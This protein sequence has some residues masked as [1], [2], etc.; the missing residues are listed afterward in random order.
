M[1][2]IAILPLILILN[3]CYFLAAQTNSQE[4]Y[5]AYISGNMV[6]WKSVIDR[7]ASNSSGKPADLA[8]LINYQYGYVGWAIGYKKTDEAKIY[9]EKAEKNLDLLDRFPEYASLV[10]SYKAA[11]YGY[12]IGMN[13]VLAPVLGKKS[14][15]CARAAIKIDE[16]NFLGWVQY[17]NTEF[18]MPSTFGGSKKDALKYYLKAQALLEAD[19]NLVRENWNYLSLL[20]V[21][22]QTYSYLGDHQSSKKYLDRILELEPGFTWAKTE[23]YQQI[24]KNMKN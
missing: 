22:A 15:D 24:Y 17:G 5:N 11:F 7:L 6:K 13:K 18:Y 19:K 20:T 16:K 3:A 21:I 23:L 12:R 2:R 9:L 14:I 1:K 10:M 4:I 8:E